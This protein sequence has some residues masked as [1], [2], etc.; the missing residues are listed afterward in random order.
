MLAQDAHAADPLRVTVEEV[1]AAARLFRSV[2]EA[3]GRRANH[4]EGGLMV[5]LIQRVDYTNQLLL[6]LLNAQRAAVSTP[7]LRGVCGY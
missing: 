6:A 1:R 5:A 3:D 7:L 2:Q 4:D